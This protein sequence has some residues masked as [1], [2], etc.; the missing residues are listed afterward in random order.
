MNN[1]PKQNIYDV[2]K[3]L[4]GKKYSKID[5]NNAIYYLREY[6]EK[7]DELEEQKNQAFL[8][9]AKAI[10]IVKV[11]T[12]ALK[13]KVNEDS[14]KCTKVNCPMQ[15]NKVPPDCNNKNCPFRTTL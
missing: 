7:K 2:I 1:K 3:K 15:Y 11:C 6:M 10:G 8:E 13:E 9:T 12:E 14:D 4:E 5:L